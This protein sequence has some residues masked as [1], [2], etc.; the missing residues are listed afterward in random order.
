L[1]E[2]HLSET[3]EKKQKIK[4]QKVKKIKKNDKES[5]KKTP[6]KEGAPDKDKMYKTTKKENKTT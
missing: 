5:Q 4:T 2:L 3:L 1:L 6:E